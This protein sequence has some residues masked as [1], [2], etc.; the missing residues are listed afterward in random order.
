MLTWQNGSQMFHARRSIPQREEFHLILA[1]ITIGIEEKFL[2]T[3]AFLFAG[4]V[5]SLKF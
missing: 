5:N 4:I 2:I 3:L 1:K